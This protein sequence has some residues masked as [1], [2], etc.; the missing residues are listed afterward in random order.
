M[1]FKCT[2]CVYEIGSLNRYVYVERNI[3]SNEAM[4]CVGVLRSFYWILFVHSQGEEPM[5]ARCL[6]LLLLFSASISANISSADPNAIPSDPVIQTTM[7]FLESSTESANTYYIDPNGTGDYPTIQAAVNIASNGDEII[8]LDGTYTGSGN[9]DIDLTGK[10]ITVR[11][12]N[13]PENCIIDCQG[14]LEEFHRAFLIHSNDEHG[15]VIKGL[16]IVNGYHKQ[17]GA[18][19]LESASPLIQN[20]IFRENICVQSDVSGGGL[21]ASN[22]EYRAI[23]CLFYRNYAQGDGG[24]VFNYRSSPSL[25]NCTFANNSA[26][27]G[28]TMFN[29]V[30][31]HVSLIN[32]L[33]F[34]N[35]SPTLANQSSSHLT[36]TNCNIVGGIANYDGSNS[37][38]TYLGVN[39]S[40]DPLFID[41][42]NDDFR[43]YYDSLCIDAGIV[44]ALLAAT[45][46]RGNLRQIDGNNDTEVLP[47]IGVYEMD[48]PDVPVLFLSQKEF[49]FDCLEGGPSPTPQLLS[50]WN[51]GPGEIMWEIQED[52][53]DW[54]V[55]NPTSGT[56]SG[57]KSDIELSV[58]SASLLKGKYQ[59]KLLIRSDSA[60]N[61]PKT[62][63]VVLDVVGPSIEVSQSS[64]IFITDDANNAPLSQNLTITNTGGGILNW[65]IQNLT[66]DWLTFSTNSGSNTAGQSANV[67]LDVVMTSLEQGV[68][69]CSFEVCDEN[70][71]N[72]PSVVQ[73]RF[74]IEVEG[75]IY[76]PYD[77]PTIQD[78]V[79]HANDGEVI[80]V[81]DGTYSGEGNYMIN[82]YGKQI[83]IQSISGY[84]NC[85]IE[86]ETH[87]DSSGFI[88]ANAE[89]NKSVIDGFNIINAGR[90]GIFCIGD[91]SPI[92]RNCR[93]SNNTAPKAS[94]FG[95]GFYCRNSSPILENCIIENNHVKKADADMA[96]GAGIYAEFS[97]MVLDRCVIRN[98]IVQDSYMGNVYGA[99]ILITDS[100]IQIKNS[101]IADNACDLIE[102]NP[103]YILAGAGL[104]SMYSIVDIV[105]STITNNVSDNTAGGIFCYSSIV[106][107]KNS[108]VAG[109]PTS[110][111]YEI[112][113]EGSNS[114]YAYPS[115]MTIAGSDIPANVDIYVG[116]SDNL[117]WQGNNID[118]DPLFVNDLTGD[119]RISPASPCIDAGINSLMDAGEK[120][121]LGHWRVHDGNCDEIEVVDMGAYEFNG[122]YFGDFTGDCVIN[123][124]DFQILSQAWATD[125]TDHNWNINVN[126]TGLDDE[127]IN[128]SDL[129]VFSNYWLEKF[130]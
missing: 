69:D 93:L 55:I 60:E 86:C 112:C 24:A 100:T 1:F 98:N 121:I 61:S 11:S 42:D 128:L 118:D 41:A 20:C 81:L 34:S 92:V 116:S 64:L 13:G 58:N 38:I 74:L 108:I 106:S 22:S 95:G 122:L 72:S 56:V 43:L 44:D 28:G 53:C 125:S 57:N 52:D 40:E 124:N 117:Y 101:L 33:I 36:L 48:T 114:Q 91:S 107:V 84:E 10:V 78:A 99:G 37:T 88:F 90:G 68:Y 109:N 83:T 82:L 130:D 80:S 97:S 50:I 18:I 23:N 79:N 5:F 104:C 96:G 49:I 21:F 9:R 123:L 87:A 4:F 17:G 16:A 75:D 15:T 73:V 113:V 65:Q 35:K 47:D 8:L 63:N 119:Y 45:D 19:H 67:A 39:I 110:D 12:E 71:N 14:T 31:S 102:N 66:C 62:V 103:T 32:C 26:N 76:V 30:S 29:Y 85:T 27:D 70:A 46:I 7:T 105:N 77:Y 115:L 94:P 3:D 25:I 126:L 6:P 51:G 120:D 54:L 59:C 111:E 89:T 2:F 129:I 127:T